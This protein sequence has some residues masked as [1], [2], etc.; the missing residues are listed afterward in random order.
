MPKSCLSV[1]HFC[2]F[3]SRAI[4]GLTDEKE[5]LDFVIPQFHNAKPCCILD[6]RRAA[7]VNA[8]K[9]KHNRPIGPLMVYNCKNS[10][11]VSI[12]L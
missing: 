1:C 8:G 4:L 7:A 10:S 2:L 11:R 3:N 9:K 5:Q 6:P 12:C